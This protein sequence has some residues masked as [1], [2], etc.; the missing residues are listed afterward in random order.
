MLQY[1]LPLTET[2]NECFHNSTQ[3]LICI[4]SSLAS[5]HKVFI[6]QNKI[7]HKYSR[8][9]LSSFRV[10]NL[11]N[12]LYLYIF[13]FFPKPSWIRTNTQISLTPLI[14]MAVILKSIT[15]LR[16]NFSDEEEISVFFSGY[17]ADKPNFS[18]FF[19]NFANKFLEQDSLLRMK[20]SSH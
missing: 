12:L 5:M 11:M 17:L 13:I 8:I 18:R 16:K 14:I 15:S 4:I 1:K 6:F 3:I 9:F 2:G 19:K 7:K 20:V 10:N